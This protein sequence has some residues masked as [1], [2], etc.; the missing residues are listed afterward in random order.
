MIRWKGRR[1]AMVWIVSAVCSV[2]F[3]CAALALMSFLARAP[4][5]LGVRNGRLAPC[6]NTPNCVSTQAETQ[7]HW[8]AP[9]TP[10]SGELTP[11]ARIAEIVRNL[12]GATVVEQSD[13]YLRAEFR[14]LLF[15]FCDDVE[16]FHDVTRG[17]IHFRSASRTGHSDLG[18]NRRRMEEIRRKFESTAPPAA[19]DAAPAKSV[20]RNVRGR[21]LVQAGR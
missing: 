15:R 2:V 17:Q 11:I 12:R 8:I 6:P 9:L 18:V 19:A 21:E 13:T 5:G 10:A 20:G 1:P 7:Q 4:E 16:F 14:S 3:P